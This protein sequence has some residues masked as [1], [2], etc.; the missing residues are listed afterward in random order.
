M[1]YGPFEVV[2]VDGLGYV[3]K[4][5]D[6]VN[7]NTIVCEYAGVV[8]I[9]ENVEKETDNDCLFDN[10][11]YNS[12]GVQIDYVIDPKPTANLGKYVSGINNIDSELRRKKNCY[13]FRTKI[14]GTIHVLLVTLRNIRRG[15]IIYYDY[16]GGDKKEMDTRLY[17]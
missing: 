16:N 14:D 7:I 4:T 13:S 12:N 9:F 5:T 15:E 17:K 10:L 8:R 6:D 11:T 2:H 3:V 1:D